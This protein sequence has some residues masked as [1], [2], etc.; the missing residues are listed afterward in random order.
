MIQSGTNLIVADNTGAKRIRCFKIL[1]G[2]R[3]R[4]A[5]VGDIIAASVKE[6]EPRQ[7]TK[8]GEK[9]KA[10]IVRQKKA[11]RRPDGSY[12]RFDDN[13]AVIVDGMEPRGNRIF[14]PVARELR[15]RFMKI[16]SMAPEVW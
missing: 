9:I 14:G 15:E 11:L 13:A 3:R 10:V 1:G 12:I 7:S 6:A 8:K 4:Y 16:I 2:T 5:Q